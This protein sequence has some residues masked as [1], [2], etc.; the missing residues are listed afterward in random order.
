MI[1]VFRCRRRTFRLSRHSQC[2]SATAANMLAVRRPPPARITSCSG[3]QGCPGP[4]VEPIAARNVNTPRGQRCSTA[5]RE[6]A[7]GARRPRQL[8]PAGGRRGWQALSCC[9][10]RQCH[11]ASPRCSTHKMLLLRVGWGAAGARRSS[12]VANSV[13]RGSQP[14]T[15]S[16]LGSRLARLSKLP[17]L[18]AV[19]RPPRRELKRGL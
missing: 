8:Q 13:L 16:T 10:T 2:G 3:H 14:W 6:A 7:R 4:G 1:N 11:R 18:V 5:E 19:R 9:A 17:K 15:A 12:T